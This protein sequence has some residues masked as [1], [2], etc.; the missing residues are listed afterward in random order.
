MNIASQIAIDEFNRDSEIAQEWTNAIAR[1]MG[2]SDAMIED[3]QLLL[4]QLGAMMAYAT[5]QTD[6]AQINQ[7]Y[8]GPRRGPVLIDES[9]IALGESLINQLPAE[10]VVVGDD[11]EI[12]NESDIQDQY[13]AAIEELISNASERDDEREQ[14]NATIR[15]FRE[16]S[17]QNPLGEHEP[18]AQ[19]VRQLIEAVWID[20]SLFEHEYG[21]ASQ[22]AREAAAEFTRSIAERTFESEGTGDIS[23]DTTETESAGLSASDNPDLSEVVPDGNIHRYR[24]LIDL[25][26]YSQRSQGSPDWVR[27]VYGELLML[28]QRHGTMPGEGRII[29]GAGSWNIHRPHGRNRSTDLLPSHGSV[30]YITSEHVPRGTILMVENRAII[31]PGDQAQ[32]TLLRTNGSDSDRPDGEHGSSPSMGT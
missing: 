19:E 14:I 2:I 3:N 16:W 18:T 9:A 6:R 25:G 13:S 7:H 26:V 12:D 17:G 10:E 11:G 22:T 28:R 8:T 24:S 23:S 32:L 30:Q 31:N 1:A 4:H 29:R 5:L 27:E 20:R 15:Q 21:T